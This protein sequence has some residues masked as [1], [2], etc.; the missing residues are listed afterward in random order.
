MLRTLLLLALTAALPAFAA[1]QATRDEVARLLTQRQWTEA[2]ALLEKVVAAEP[3][4]AEA[5]NSL[6]QTFLARSDPAG[7]VSAS[8]KATALDASNSGYFLQLGHAYG[9]SA[10][11]AG[12]F[13]KVGF[14][15]KCKAAYDKAV[16]L[17]P[18][19][20]NARWSLMEYCRQAPGFMGGGMDKAYAQAAEIRTLDARRGRAAYASLYSAEKRF[21]EAFA[22]YEEVL[23]E[24]PDDDDA[25]FAIGRL[26]ARSGEQLD[27]GLAA[28]RQLAL[29]PDRASDARLPTFIGNILEKQGDKPGAQAAYEAALAIDPKFTQALEALRKLK[30]NLAGTMQS[31]L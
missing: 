31:K 10:V 25:L 6:A 13:S 11:K 5:W 7:A 3:G 1:D 26:A 30:E 2:Q 18:K 14:A 8:E 15:N 28:L 24:K 19:N 27:R 21:S 23:R 22:L 4:N 9:L 20:I 16:E 17:D 12:L 29:H